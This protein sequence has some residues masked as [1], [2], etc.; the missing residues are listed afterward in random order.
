MQFYEIVIKCRKNSNKK[1]KIVN[2][3]IVG[4]VAYI[5][6]KKREHQGNE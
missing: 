6:G 5:R 4:F 3:H 1:K 2:N